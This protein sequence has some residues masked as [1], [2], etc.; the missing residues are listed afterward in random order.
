MAQGPTYRVKFRR[1]REGKTNY[2]RRRRLLLSRQ[3][4]LVV[5]KTNTQIIVQVI[6]AKVVGDITEASAI[7]KELAEY[8]WVSSS[9][10]MPASYLTG[11]LAGLRAKS[12]GIKRAILDIGL[13][14]P[15]RG[16]RIYSA[17]KGVLDAGIDVPHSP[18]V[19]PEE[20][21]IF[22]LLPVY[23]LVDV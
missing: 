4:R 19:L 9:S 7:S 6:N 3:H 11:L 5:R 1:R 13:N 15:V 22:L 18:D 16:S 21:R 2:Y 10:N 12:R 17:L 23:T 14:P 8:G 20:D